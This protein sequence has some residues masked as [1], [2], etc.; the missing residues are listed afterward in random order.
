MLIFCKFILPYNSLFFFYLFC[1]WKYIYIFYHMSMNIRKTFGQN[2]KIYRKQK[3]L[4]QEQLAERLNISVKH[5]STLETG[6]TFASPELME[7]IS[8]VL[9]VSVSSLFYEVNEKSFD[10][11]DF[12]KINFIIEEQLLKTIITVK[13]AIH[14]LK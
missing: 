8:T 6:K 9:K 14:Q 4:S 10:D 5:L 12:S 3:L 7:K 1:N 2:I 13:Q 11:S